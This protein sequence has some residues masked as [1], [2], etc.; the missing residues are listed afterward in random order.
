[1]CVRFVAEEGGLDDGLNE[2]VEEDKG[3]EALPGDAAQPCSIAE[4]QVSDEADPKENGKAADRVEIDEG[5]PEAGGVST[6]PWGEVAGKLEEEEWIVIQGG[7][8]ERGPAKPRGETEGAGTEVGEQGVA[9]KEEAEGEQG[10]GGAG[11]RQWMDVEEEDEDDRCEQEVGAPGL[12]A[13][14][15]VPGEDGVDEDEQ[16]IVARAALE[17][18]DLRGDQD[19][20][21]D[22]GADG[23]G[24]F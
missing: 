6:A 12:E 18:D 3:D 24:A 9:A 13:A 22:E 23:A 2:E 20:G 5:G 1:M 19:E 17:E 10:K 8:E 16:G 7:A 11:R 15:E 14:R 4:E 21:G